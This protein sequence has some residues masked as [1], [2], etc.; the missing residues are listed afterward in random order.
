MH[1]HGLPGE[2]GESL[3]LEVLQ[4]CEDV[5]LRDVSSGLV[6]ERDDLSAQ[7]YSS[8]LTCPQT[9][10]CIFAARR[11]WKSSVMDV[12]RPTLVRIGGRVYRKNI[13]H[14]Q[15]QQQEE[16]ENFYTGVVQHRGA[17]QWHGDTADTWCRL[18]CL[19]A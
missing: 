17:L 5:V 9:A 19:C 6:V 15:V 2:V 11:P 14:E 4:S 8:G 18:W 7:G 1:R 16:E 3:S 12:L 10:A 13:I